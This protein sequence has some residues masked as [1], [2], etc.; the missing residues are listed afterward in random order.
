M[1]LPT[2]AVS[3][4][5]ALPNT[6]TRQISPQRSGRSSTPI[7]QAENIDR[8]PSVARHS[9]SIRP[10]SGTN[11]RDSGCCSR[12]TRPSRNGCC[13]WVLPTGPDQLPDCTADTRSGGSCRSAHH[14]G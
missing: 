3:P 8:G 9:T 14:S 6:S 5:M 12:T 1:P 4:S 11:P 2:A 13:P 10:Y 7:I